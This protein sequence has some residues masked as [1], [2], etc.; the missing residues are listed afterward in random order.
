MQKDPAVTGSFWLGACRLRGLDLDFDVD[1]GGKLQPL[2]RIDGV[3][4]WL[5]DVE[6]TLVD[7]HLE[8][9]TAVF[10]LVGAADHGVH[11]MLSRQ[12]HRSANLGVRPK[13][14]LDDLLRRLVDDLV[15][16]GLESDA[17]LLLGVSHVLTRFV[18]N[19]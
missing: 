1:A 16:V 4:A 8:V 18:S 15:I 3:G 2:Q 7:L 12:R 5:Q 6:E 10:V 9:F 19:S 11:V 14:R 13:D 17:D